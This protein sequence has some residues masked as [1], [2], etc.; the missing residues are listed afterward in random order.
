MG[1]VVRGGG[2]WMRERE[3]GREG[4]RG[5][6]GERGVRGQRGKACKERVREGWGEGAVGPRDMLV[7][8]SN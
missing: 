8:R 2:E 6:G 7:W 1:E 3:G 5:R 4:L